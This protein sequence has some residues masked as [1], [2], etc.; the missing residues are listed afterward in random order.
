MVK[1]YNPLELDLVPFYDIASEIIETYKQNIKNIDAIG[2]GDLLDSIKFDVIVKDENTIS[3]QL[4]VND[5]YYFIEWGRGKTVTSGW[6]NPIEDLSKWLQSKKDRGK[7]IPRVDKPIPT[8]QKEIRQVAYAI[9]RKITEHG[10]YGFDSH[11]KQPLGKA[12]DEAKQNGLIDKI[13][14][15]F[16]EQYNV[17]LI[18]DI[19]DLA[20]KAKPKKAQHTK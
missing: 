17:D 16:T 18:V 6:D 10:Y 8:T 20:E 12:L 2:T 14:N 9:Y 11:G 1:Q 5:Y 19:Q 7:L 3:L 4:I 13:K 15:V